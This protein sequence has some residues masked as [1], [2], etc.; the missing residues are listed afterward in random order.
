MRE[1]AAQLGGTLAV[2]PRDGGWRVDL[3]LPVRQST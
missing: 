1:R 3:R 2:G